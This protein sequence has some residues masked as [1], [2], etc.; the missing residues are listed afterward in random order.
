MTNVADEITGCMVVTSV[1]YNVILGYQLLGVVGSQTYWVG[2]YLDVAIS[3]MQMTDSTFG[4][5]KSD[6]T[7]SVPSLSMNNVLFFI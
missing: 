5:R 1:N 4:F 2:F 7:I 3:G 6:A